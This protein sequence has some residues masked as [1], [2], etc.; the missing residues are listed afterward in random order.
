MIQVIY[1][2][3]VHNESEA[4]PSPAYWPLKFFMLTVAIYEIQAI[5]LKKQDINKH[6]NA[7]KK[8]KRNK[9]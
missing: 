9:E 7:G 4:K 6:I 1:T 5:Q 3:C 8:Q 2:E